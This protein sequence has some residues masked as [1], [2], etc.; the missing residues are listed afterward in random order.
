[1]VLSVHTDSYKQGWQVFATGWKSR[2]SMEKNHPG[3]NIVFAGKNWLVFSGK[4]WFEPIV[5]KRKTRN[6]SG[7]EIANVNSL[8]RHCTRTKIQ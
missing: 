5:G 4:N 6:S 2:F 1:M 8:R 3:Q 7:D